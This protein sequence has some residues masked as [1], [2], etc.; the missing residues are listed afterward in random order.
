MIN[1]FINNKVIVKVN[2]N[3]LLQRNI[4][5]NNNLINLNLHNLLIKKENYQIVKFKKMIN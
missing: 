5:N 4:K 2:I 1:K 3:N